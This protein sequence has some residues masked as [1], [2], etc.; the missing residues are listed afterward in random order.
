MKPISPSKS[1]LQRSQPG[2]FSFFAITFALTFSLGGCSSKTYKSTQAPEQVTPQPVEKKNVESEPIASA[3]K[4]EESAEAKPHKKVSTPESA[5]KPREVKKQATKT[6]AKVKKAAPTKVIKKTESTAKTQK[7][8]STQKAKAAEKAKPNTVVKAPKP[9][10]K[11]VPE[12][13]TLPKQKEVAQVESESETTV[14]A[15]PALSLNSLDALPISIGDKWTL[16]R[17]L[18]QANARTCFLSYTP[19]KMDDGQGLTLAHLKVTHDSI[20]LK[21]KS[22]IDTSYPAAGLTI[23]N[24]PQIPIE[25]LFNISSIIYKDHYNKAIQQM[26]AGKQATFAIG[27]W[28]T[29]PVTQTYP[30]SFDLTNFPEAY[31]TLQSCVKL[32]QQL[33]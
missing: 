10:P 23:D 13:A 22:N 14:T 32:E 21:T 4:K 20:L 27:F 1:L 28:P 12:V 5:S 29:W 31:S 3:P 9:K 8:A 18:S 30:V 25:K 33:K 7:T 16:D 19:Q 11:T 2:L 6:N 17:E 24:H 26:I 15:A